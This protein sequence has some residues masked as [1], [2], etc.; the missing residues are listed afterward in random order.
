MKSEYLFILEDDPYDHGSSEEGR[1]GRDGERVDE[2]G[3]EDITDEKQTG[4]DKCGGGDGDAMVGGAE[5]TTGDVG[6]GDTDK[7]DGSAESGDATGKKTCSQH[8]I[9]ARAR[10]INS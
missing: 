3:A 1:D 5:D 2:E 7:S 6:D 4:T 9:Q 8:Y 10:N